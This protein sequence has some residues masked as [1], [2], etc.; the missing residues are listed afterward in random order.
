[1]IE[2]NERQIKGEQGG[3]T[4][5]AIREWEKANV[6][7]QRDVFTAYLMGLRQFRVLQRWKCG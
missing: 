3:Q 1:M 2:E 7:A 6:E 4:N 5:K